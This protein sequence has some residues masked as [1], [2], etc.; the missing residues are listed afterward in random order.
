[1]TLRSSLLISLCLTT[2]I[3]AQAPSVPEHRA[4]MPVPR[5]GPWMIKHQAINAF[6]KKGPY[7]LIFL[8]DS[9]TEGWGNNEVW[10]K[11][12]DH[13]RSANMGIGG[14]RTEHVLWRI[15]NGN[16][17]GLAP[18]VAVLM[19]GTN[20]SN[21]SEYTADQIGDG[22]IAIVHEL[23]R[24]LPDTK[25][26]LVAIFPRGAEP[27]PQR[28]KNA[29]ASAKAA[30]V[31]DGEMVHFIDI[32]EK[33]L[34]ATGHLAKDIMPDFLHLS[35]EG[36]AIWARSIEPKLAELLGDDPVKD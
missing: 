5:V 28:D 3:L 1:M 9:I 20:N 18:K 10:Q 11:Y 19:I 4:T 25:I 22:I 6:A 30:K 31:A 8:G 33:F 21:G 13:R 27:N 2:S 26:L 14:D 32:G 17:D 35:P 24:R 29:Q 16:I 34:D 36:Y 15:Q 23:R 7:D 12:Y